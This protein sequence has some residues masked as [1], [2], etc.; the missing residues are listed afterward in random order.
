VQYSVSAHKLVDTDRIQRIL[1]LHIVSGVSSYFFGKVI[2]RIKKKWNETIQERVA[3]TSAT[4]AQLKNIKMMG[5]APV[6]SKQIQKLRVDELEQFK[7]YRYVLMWF[8]VSSKS[9]TAIFVSERD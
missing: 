2:I 6:I 1:T 8:T 9:I 4:L 3:K 7:R 5:L